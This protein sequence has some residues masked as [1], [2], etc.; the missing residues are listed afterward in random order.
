MSG[1]QVSLNQPVLES[2]SDGPCQGLGPGLPT[3][4]RLDSLLTLTC[5][6]SRF[7]SCRRLFNSYRQGNSSNKASVSSNSSSRATMASLG[8][9]ATPT[10]SRVEEEGRGVLLVEAEVGLGLPFQRA[11]HPLEQRK[12]L[13]KGR[14]C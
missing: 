6:C 9:R 4:V 1:K 13:K 5:C 10:T 14:R 8:P 3:M 11:K 2:E 12:E 7:S